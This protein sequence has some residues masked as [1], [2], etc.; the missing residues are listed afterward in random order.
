VDTPW[1]SGEQAE[2]FA[3]VL[4]GVGTRQ[5]QT[6][7]GYAGTGKTV[8]VWA[9]ADAIPDFTVCAFT[10]KAAHVL[11]RKGVAGARTIQSLIY[12]PEEPPPRKPGDPPP[13]PVFRLKELDALL[14]DGGTPCQERLTWAL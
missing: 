12:W 11:R 7:G 8:L 2:V 13:E 9:L 6:V 14:L 3:Q 4:G 5:V 10:G 1:L